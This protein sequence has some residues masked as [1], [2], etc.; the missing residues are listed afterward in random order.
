M[1]GVE[2][3]EVAVI[4]SIIIR[5]KRRRWGVRTKGEGNTMR[6]ATHRPSRRWLPPRL[7]MIWGARQGKE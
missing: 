3:G 6:G 7:E 4:A 2:G 1:A 5:V